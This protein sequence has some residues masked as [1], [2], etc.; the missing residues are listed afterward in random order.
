MDSKIPVGEHLDDNSN[1]LIPA[2]TMK[3]L[4]LKDND[5]AIV[6]NTLQTVCKVSP[7]NEDNYIHLGVNARN[8]VLDQKTNS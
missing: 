8:S 6:R 5:T 3:Q 4:N 1:V 7:N 2:A